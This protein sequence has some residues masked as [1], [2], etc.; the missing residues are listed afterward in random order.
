MPS[1]NGTR[2][3]PQRRVFRG[4]GG[5]TD[6]NLPPKKTTRRRVKYQPGGEDAGHGPNQ[7]GGDE[8]FA[9]D[10]GR[11]DD[12]YDDDNVEDE[13]NS[14]DRDV[15]NLALGEG[16]D[17]DMIPHDG[18]FLLEMEHLHRR[19]EHVQLSLQTSRGLA[20]PHTWRMNC[21]LPT[22]N[23]VREWRCIL[24]YHNTDHSTFRESDEKV[25]AMPAVRNN[26]S[27]S[28]RRID[29][30]N[31]LQP[32][33]QKVF[34]LIQMSVQTGPLVGSNPG[35]FKRCGGEVASM[36]LSYLCEI[37]ELAGVVKNTINIAKK[38]DRR[39]I[40]TGPCDE[41]PH[42]V[43]S[44]QFETGEHFEEEADTDCSSNESVESCDVSLFDSDTSGS[45]GSI[46]CE[47]GVDF[48]PAQIIDDTLSES[49]SPTSPDLGVSSPSDTLGREII[50]NLQKTLLFTEK[51]SQ[52]MYQ[53][54]CNA[55]NAIDRNLSPSKSASKLQSLKSKKQTLKE[56]KIQRKLKKKKKSDK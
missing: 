34:A 30:K 37:A 29:V 21:L 25:E 51:Q 54:L 9:G 33:S 15:R 45:S 16:A 47:D 53:W 36:A 26:D 2:N 23:V 10:G 46:N 52:K 22:R 4:R 14:L 49:K 5:P 48:F 20:N 38:C 31:D 27:K 13:S 50:G 43:A 7:A 17:D 6:G 24:A 40:L 35:Y 12:N 3:H 44:E 18:K 42:D 8:G 1:F 39:L 55:E 19:I 32:T 28:P 41:E 11:G 56:L